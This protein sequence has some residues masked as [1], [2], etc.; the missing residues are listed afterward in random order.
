[1]SD[2]QVWDLC[3]NSN[4]GSRQ[5]ESIDFGIPSAATTV[6]GILMRVNMVYKY[7]KEQRHAEYLR[8]K[9]KYIARAKRWAEK[10]PS[11]RKE[12]LEAKQKEAEAEAAKHASSFLGGGG[13][14][15]SFNLSP[16]L[17]SSVSLS[18]LPLNP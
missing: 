11:K 12:I 7:T 13:D 16:I 18:I 10:N 2:Y 8:N 5:H 15:T 3:Y 6:G 17:S 1:M 4:V 14:L 9:D